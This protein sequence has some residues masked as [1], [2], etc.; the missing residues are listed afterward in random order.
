MLGHMHWI[1]VMPAITTPFRSDDSVDTEFLSQHV[2]WLIS[3]GSTGIVALGSL[4]E[5][6]TLSEGEKLDILRTCV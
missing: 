3:N 2:D 6:A 4:G 5:S 1:G